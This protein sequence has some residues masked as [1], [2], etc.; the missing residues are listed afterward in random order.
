M[1][2]HLRTMARYNRWANERLYAACREAGDGEV[3]RPR[4]AF[5]GSIHAT[6]NHLI[7]GD[8]LWLDRLEGRPLCGWALDHRPCA[9]MDAL[10]EA[11][12]ALDLRIVRVLDGMADADIEGDLVYR[13][14]IDPGREMRTPRHLCWLHMFNHQTHHRGQIHDMLSQTDVPPPPLDLIYY[15]R[16]NA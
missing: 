16:E 14:A 3:I 11:R 13:T 1:L 4:R 12:R 5:F 6:L 9:D 2:A 7:V 8:T 15:V 10:E